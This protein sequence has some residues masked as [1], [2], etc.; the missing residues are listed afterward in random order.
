MFT[1]SLTAR[2]YKDSMKINFDEVPSVVAII[3]SRKFPVRRLHQ[4]EE[5]VNELKPQT[6]VVSGGAVGVDKTAEV[7]ALKRWDEGRGDFPKPDIKLPDPKLPSPQRYYARNTVIVK[8]VLH[9]V[10]HEMGM[11]FAFLLVDNQT[12]GTDNAL[13]TARALNIPYLI[14]RIDHRGTWLATWCSPAFALGAR[15]QKI[16]IGD[17][18]PCLDCSR[19]NYMN[20]I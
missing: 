18:A 1:L 12:H 7:A 2:D 17:E 13:S 20:L 10:G 8:R 15:W 19:G 4:I 9:G 5:F 11:I 14:F 6:L 3:G 16:L